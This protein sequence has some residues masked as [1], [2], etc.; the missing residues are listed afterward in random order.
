MYELLWLLLPVAA[1][2]GW[3]LAKRDARVKVAAAPS[4]SSD[5]FTG[6]NYLVNEQP[7]KAIECFVRMLEVDS[8]T[9][10]IHLAVG[11]LFRQR[12][13]VDRAI[14]IHHNLISRTT[15]SKQQRAQA[16]LELALDY[17][18]AGLFDR[19]ES[20]CQELIGMEARTGRALA[21]LSDIYQQEKEWSQA[22]AVTRRL[23]DKTGQPMAQAIAQF[24]CELAEEARAAGDIKAARERLAQALDTDPKCV[25]ASMIRGEMAAAAG[26]CR[27]AIRAYQQVEQQD[28][29]YLPEVIPALVQSYLTCDARQELMDYL[30]RVFKER[31]GISVLLALVDLIERGQGRA[32]ALAFLRRH[33]HDYPSLRGAAQLMKMDLEDTAIGE[34]D[35]LTLLN[36]TIVQALEE[37]PVYQC[38]QCGFAG[39][40]LHWHCPG[41]KRW[42]TVKP[43]HGLEGE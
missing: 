26:D 30:T 43:I 33:L 7:D 6:L 1:V 12:G 37:K 34:R 39:K 24:Y 11:N 41:C 29:A 31:G 8:D 36:D 9:V 38:T 15:L 14:R 27:E 22:I 21:L 25:R 13:E 16:L 35:T 18:R 28:P 4:L 3:I 17:M 40:V 32:E 20:L 10:E 2:S 42:N 23:Q 19:A 5:Y